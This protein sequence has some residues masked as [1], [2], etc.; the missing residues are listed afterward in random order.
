MKKHNKVYSFFMMLLFTVAALANIINA[1]FFSGH[2]EGTIQ[3]ISYNFSA[4]I[5]L[6]FALIW[7]HYDFYKKNK[8]P[9]TPLQIFLTFATVILAL[10]N[11]TLL[12]N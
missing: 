4:I 2:G 10:L 6:D 1:D 9:K 3:K 12:K 7:L 11:I 5:L 8:R